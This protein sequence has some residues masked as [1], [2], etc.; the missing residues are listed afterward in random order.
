M[1]PHPTTDTAQSPILR[2]FT[3][4]YLLRQDW[5]GALIVACGL[6]PQGAAL[7]LAS[8]IAGAVCLSI[9]SNPALLKEALRSGSCDFM[10]NTLDEALRTMKNEV[11]KHRPL[12]VGLQGDPAQ[13]L[14]EILEL[15]VTPE[16]FTD[17]TGS[18]AHQEAIHTFK[19]SGALIVH[20]ESTPPV[21]GEEILDACALLDRFA[22]ER[23]WLLHSFSFGTQAALRAF[24]AHALTLLPADDHIR[25][26]W[27]Q[28]VPRILQREHPIR[29]TLWV[30]EAEKQALQASLPTPV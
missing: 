1:S 16:L 13:V 11:R 8:N 28:A 6:N 3:V 17:L 14:Q 2:A 25:R 5:G 24:D 19:S 10:V 27:L 21:E 18:S 15:G 20:L 26:R 30:S 23:Q 22:H 7:A 4:L 29:R 9:E 12:S